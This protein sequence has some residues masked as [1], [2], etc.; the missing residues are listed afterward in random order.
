MNILVVS[1][2]FFPTNSPRAFRTTELAK[3]FVKLG[4]QVTIVVPQIEYDYSSFLAEYPLRMVHYVRPVE[5][6]KFI[7]VSIIDRIIFRVLNQFANYPDVLLM[8]SLQSVL[9]QE[10]FDYDLLISVAMPHTIH[11]TI[12]KLYSRKINLA[13]VWVADCG[14]PYMLT[15]SGNYRP[16]F[17]FKWTEKKWCRLCNYITVPTSSSIKGYYPEF[18]DKIRVIPQAFNFDEV[19]KDA[20]KPHP[21]PTF[22]YS[23]SFIPNRRDLRPILDYLIGKGIRFRFIIYTNQVHYFDSYKAL[24]GEM[25]EIKQYIPRL[26]LLKILSTMD[27]LLNLDN[28]TNVQT[29]SKLIDYALTERPILSLD[30]QRLDTEKFDAFLNGDYS[31]KYVVEN[32]SQYDINVVAQHFLDLCKESH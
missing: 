15:D 18:K 28:G 17:Y 10:K 20:Y 30:S 12:G 19:E 14:D 21:I 22:A 13:K 23:G 1:G 2:S 4:H 27:F 6:R 7:G 11:W 26:E 5:Q 29:P 24:M 31:K 32:I 8:R 16:P 9:K 3:R 25:L